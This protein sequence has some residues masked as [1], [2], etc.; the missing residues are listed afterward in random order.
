MFPNNITANNFATS[1]TPRN[2]ISLINQH[3]VTVMEGC[4]QASAIVAEL[5]KTAKLIET[6]CTEQYDNT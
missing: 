5:T 2:D 3:N 1:T 6:V 4:I